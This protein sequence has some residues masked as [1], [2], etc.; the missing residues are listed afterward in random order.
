[1]AKKKYYVVWAGKKT[2]VFDTWEKCRKQIAQYPNALYKSFETNELAQ[3]AFKGNPYDFIGK[4]TPQKVKL[5]PEQLS[6]L[7]KPIAQSISVDGAWSSSTGQIE[8]QGVNTMTG[9]LLFRSQPYQDGTNNIAEFLAIVHALAYCQQRNWQMPIYSDSKVA[10]GW[11]RQKKI[12]TNH[13][14]TEKNR[15][16]FEIIDRANNWLQNNTYPNKILKWETEAWGENPADFG[17]K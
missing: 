10:M 15:K 12:G 8:Y 4:T 14:K 3:I 17:R 5:T 16:L 9:D 13:P 11:V 7:G 2:G 1:M 6:F